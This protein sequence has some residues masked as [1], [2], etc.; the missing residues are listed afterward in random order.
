MELVGQLHDTSVAMIEKYYGRFIHNAMDD[1]PAP[2][3]CR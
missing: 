3:R 1:S 2:R